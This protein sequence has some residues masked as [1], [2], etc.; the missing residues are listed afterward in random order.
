MLTAGRG[1]VRWPDGGLPEGDPAGRPGP[2]TPARAP[3]RRP[4]P[5][6]PARPARRAA[7]GGD[8]RHSPRSPQG[9]PGPG[10]DD[11]GVSA[12]AVADSA[13]TPGEAG[14]RVSEVSDVG[15]G[16]RRARS[17]QP[18]PGEEGRCGSECR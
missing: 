13:A 12:G 8:V 2:A 6:T 3:A 1:E 9:G 16:P 4:T 10:R 11:P 18:L 17:R 15:A 7:R 14:R 5:P